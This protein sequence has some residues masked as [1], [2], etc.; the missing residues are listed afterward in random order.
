MSQKE[1]V[2][3]EGE[4]RSAACR[5]RTL[6]LYTRHSNTILSTF[7]SWKGDPRYYFIELPLNPVYAIA[8]LAIRLGDPPYFLGTYVRHLLSRPDLFSGVCP[9]CAARLRPFAYVGSPLSGRLDLECFCPSCGRTRIVTVSGWKVRN[10]VLRAAQAEDRP[11]HEELLRADP[12]FSAAPIEELLRFLGI[13]EE[14]FFVKRKRT[15]PE[16][17]RVGEG[18]EIDSYPGR[19]IVIVK[20]GRV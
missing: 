1:N 17:I 15:S 19:G 11:R 14:E 6:L 13:P 9:K 12:A 18:T 5:E 8:G 4:M 20:N 3:H 10:E 7:D 16:R 2:S